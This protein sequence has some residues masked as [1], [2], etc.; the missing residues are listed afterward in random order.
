MK[1]ELRSLCAFADHKL[2]QLIPDRSYYIYFLVFSIYNFTICKRLS[3]SLLLY[4]SF[5]H[6]LVSKRSCKLKKKNK[7]TSDNLS[8]ILIILIKLETAK[9]QK[10]AN[11]YFSC[12]CMVK[13]RTSQK[14]NVLLYLLCYNNFSITFFVL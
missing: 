11:I 9:F 4:I 2:P 13:T 6:R 8:S 10:V 7:Q 5:P 3:D 14:Q 12:N 1:F